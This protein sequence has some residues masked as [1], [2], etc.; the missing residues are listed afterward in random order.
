[1]QDP[2]LKPD[3]LTCHRTGHKKLCKSL[4]DKCPLWMKMTRKDPRTD[5]VIDEWLCGDVWD[6][7]LH[8][9]AIREMRGVH[10]ALNSFRNETVKR[11]DSVLH[12]AAEMA[13]VNQVQLPRAPEPME[14]IPDG[15]NND[16][17]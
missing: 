7:I 1:M 2:L 15:Q 4:R 14:V 11:S 10:A 5:A 17:S 13:L 16:S 6:T 3:E 12:L 9:E 8:A